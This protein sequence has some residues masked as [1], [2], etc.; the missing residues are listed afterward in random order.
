MPDLDEPPTDQSRPPDRAEFAAIPRALLE[1]KPSGQA[2]RLYAVLSLWPGAKT[3]TEG[4]GVPIGLDR[5]TAELGLYS[6]DQ[7]SRY[8]NELARLGYLTV[9]R[10]SYTDGRRGPNR[11]RLHTAP[12]ARGES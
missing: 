2:I 5:L 1:A 9:E 12:A 3:S 7:T 10:H 6:Q 4:T 11:Y 8:V